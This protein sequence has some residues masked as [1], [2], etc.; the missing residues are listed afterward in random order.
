MPDKNIPKVFR[1]L[2]CDMSVENADIVGTPD[3]FY[4]VNKSLAKY[5]QQR[6]FLIFWIQRENG[7]PA[8]S[9]LMI[10]FCM[11]FQTIT[12]IPIAF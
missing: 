5:W 9:F 11:P 1:L 6:V 2:L 8:A 12:M 7:L 4:M 10:G 3:G